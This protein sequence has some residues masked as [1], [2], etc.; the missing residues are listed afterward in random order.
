MDHSVKAMTNTHRKV[1][2]SRLFNRSR[3][4]NIELETLYKRYIFKLNQS[5][6][7]SV[8]L[9]FSLLTFTLSILEYYYY[10]TITVIGLACSIECITFTVLFILNLTKAM[11]D[12]HLIGVCYTIICL[13][14]I[15]CLIYAP[16]DIHLR[17]PWL[18]AS[19]WDRQHTAAEGVWQV[20]LVTFV[21]YTL[22]P[23]KTRIS[24]L[25]GTIVCTA[26]LAISVTSAHLF[27]DY[28]W[29]QIWANGLI[30]V[31]VNLAGLF[32]DHLM[33]RAGRKAFLNTR[34]CISARLEMEDENEKLERL[35][36]S[37]LPQHVAMEMKRDILSPKETGQFHKIYIQKHENV[38]ILFADIVGFTVLASHCSAS[39]LVRLL[40]EL[41]G[42]FDQLANDNHCLRIKILGDCY[43]CVS[44]LPEPRSDH[45]HCAVEMGLDMIDAISSVVESTDVNLNMRVGIHTGRVL[46][47]VIGLRK[48]QYD[49][50]SN[51]VTLANSMEAAGEPGRVHI[52]QA[53]LDCLHNEYD[54]E[55][56]NGA[57]RNATLRQH[58]VVTHFII[59]PQQ[60]RKPFLFNTLSVRHLAGTAGRR[61]L[62]FKNVSSVLVQLLHS[63][64]FNVDVPFSNMAVASMPQITNETCGG[65]GNKILSKKQKVADKLRKPF[66]KRHSTVQHQA[67][68]R[69]NKY[70]AQA[71]EAR[72]VDREKSTH[73]NPITLCFKDHLK[74]RQYHDNRDYGFGMSMACALV[75]FI[76]LT[77]V[78]VAILP[79]TLMLLGLFVIALLWITAILGLIISARL[80]WMM[81]DISKYFLI[82][83][84]IMIF[85]VAL[86][87]AVAQ[88]NVFCCAE[89]AHCPNSTIIHPS[90]FFQEYRAC[91]LP[92]YIALSCVLSFLPLAIFLKLPVLL[93]AALIVPMATVF[94]L[95]I[96]FTHLQLFTCHDIRSGSP[97]PLHMISA[98]VVV[99]FS[100]AVLIHGR[101]VEWT[102]RLDFLWNAQA[103]EEK[104]E[105]HELQDSNKR[106]LF[107]LLPAHVATHFLDNQFRN[108]MELYSHFYKKIGVMFA[109]VPNF[110]E[111]YDELDGNNQGVECLRLLNEIIVDFDQI[112]SKECYRSIDK[113]KTVGSTYMAAVGLI[114]EYRIPD[115]DGAEAAEYMKLLVDVVFEMKEKLGD[116]NEN[117]Y[118]NFMLR[119]GLNIGPAVA[120]VIGARKPQYDIWGNTVN[121][122]SRMDSTSKPNY[123]QCTEEVYSLLKDYPYI[124][125]CRGTVNI[126][127]KGEMTTYFLIDKRKTTH[128]I[129]HDFETQISSYE[130]NKNENENDFRN[131]DSN[132]RDTRSKSNATNS[133]NKKSND[134]TRQQS[135][136]VTDDDHGHCLPEST[137]GSKKRTHP[138]FR[139]PIDSNQILARARTSLN[140]FRRPLPDLPPTIEESPKSEANPSQC[141]SSPPTCFPASPCDKLN[142]TD[143]HS[144]ST[145]PP[146]LPPHQHQ[147]HPTHY[148]CNLSN[149]VSDAILQGTDQSTS[150]NDIILSRENGSQLNCVQFPNL[151]DNSNLDH[152]ELDYFQSHISQP[153]AFYMPN[154]ANIKSSIDRIARLRND[155][156]C[157]SSSSTTNQPD[158]CINIPHEICS[159]NV[160]PTSSNLRPS[161]IGSSFYRL[162]STSSSSSL[163]SSSSPSSS[164]SNSSKDTENRPFLSDYN[165]PESPDLINNRLSGDSSNLQWVYPDQL[166]NQDQPLETISRQNDVENQ[167][168]VLSSAAV[169]SSNNSHQTDNPKTFNMPDESFHNIQYSSSLKSSGTQTDPMRHHHHSHHSHHPHHS[170][171]HPHPHHG[172]ELSLEKQISKNRASSKS[173]KEVNN[174]NSN[175]RRSKQ[176]KVKRNENRRF[177]WRADNREGALAPLLGRQNS[178]N[179]ECV[180][181][182]TTEDDNEENDLES[183]EYAASKEEDE[184]PPPYAG[185]PAS[186]S[187]H[188]SKSSFAHLLHFSDR[189]RKAS[190]PEYYHQSNHNSTSEHG[191]SESAPLIDQCGGVVRNFP[192]HIDQSN[193]NCHLVG[194]PSEMMVKQSDSCVSGHESSSQDLNTTD[195]NQNV[196]ISNS[197]QEED[198]VGLSS[199]IISGNNDPNGSSVSQIQHRSMDSS[200]LSPRGMKVTQLH[201][202]S[203]LQAD[204]SFA[205]SDKTLGIDE[206]TS[207]S[208]ISNLTTRTDLLD[209][210]D[211]SEDVTREEEIDEE[212]EVD[213]NEQCPGLTVDDEGLTSNEGHNLSEFD[214]HINLEDAGGHVGE[215]E[216]EVE[217]CKDDDE[218]DDGDG[219][220]NEQEGNFFIS[221]RCQY[222]GHENLSQ[223]SVV[224]DASSFM[225]AEEVAHGVSLLA[226]DPGHEGDID[227]TSL[228]S[229]ASSRLLNEND[230]IFNFVS[231]SEIENYAVVSWPDHLQG[232]FSAQLTPNNIVHENEANSDFEINYSDDLNQCQ[233]QEEDQVKRL[234]LKGGKTGAVSE[235]IESELFEP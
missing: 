15:F 112:L 37:V 63:I 170:H 198:L 55:P 120:G 11:R 90:S 82:R 117:S 186:S 211:L 127:G 187:C 210:H 65:D 62:S 175:R 43:Y 169:S 8:L 176:A 71:I 116:I 144:S 161:S 156:P 19:W 225:D 191:S 158:V 103:N 201:K 40:N 204:D 195:D 4:E 50:W 42:R 36:L 132:Q 45:A 38:S 124:F 205:Q 141:S 105:M 119:V 89:D 164:L 217:I 125:K 232:S 92:H 21:V 230:P 46:C 104:L 147:H 214:V 47:G 18:H 203:Q 137:Q 9:L 234:S 64:K 68:N 216:D 5:S 153:S 110:N 54:V 165:N 79:R 155:F 138:P 197:I 56:G 235:E 44:G 58:N 33:E 7:L 222:D 163:E 167:F 53:T 100:I 136:D 160:L 93:K 227:D 224:N 22:L 180:N 2:F 173:A 166:I 194:Q 96:F 69:V 91:P 181:E 34:N 134:N 231:D 86:I 121:V 16:I 73:V 29:N 114:P 133:S 185:A 218:D 152:T 52:T 130:S 81:K 162:S 84:A 174:S 142:E 108:N 151:N 14:F 212:A 172:R 10:S 150:F 88:V 23:V 78:Q 20:V 190:L 12:D 199:L 99:I 200:N 83:L 31:C 193:V 129:D 143:H 233:H 229:R 28:K 66:K 51:D 26:H 97:I 182:T 215:L 3:F 13:A 131:T 148:H 1:A 60:R 128:E 189:N 35:L 48:W 145:Q 126:K 122:A 135:T 179:D 226:P 206:E 72:S 17:H 87:Y 139:I 183:D 123:T 192:P 6:I 178:S 154:P 196:S 49:V 146:P 80:K 188:Q 41:F 111:F 118:N 24:L 168:D 95:V 25:F 94:L 77:G 107:N 115:E 85:T 57:D 102:S 140:V 207:Y 228:S 75:I 76:L 67:T 98:V 32:V 113:I 184:D 209:V 27:V 157:T 202:A 109:S 101:Q 208:K 221:S 213:D 171:P 220:V 219:D 61:K 74:E 223:L 59:P 39:D 149:T 30:F 177:N 70:L 106:I 159:E